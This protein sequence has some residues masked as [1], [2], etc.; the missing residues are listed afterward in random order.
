MVSLRDNT[1]MTDYWRA[2]GFD[3]A[4]LSDARDYADTPDA[5]VYTDSTTFGF[6]ARMAFTGAILKAADAAAKRAL[7]GRRA[8]LIVK[9]LKGAGVHATGAKS[10]N[11]NAR[12]TLDS[13]DVKGCLQR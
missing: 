9:Q 7:S 11:L 10:P 8:C 13:D 5:P 1:R 3:E 12:P 4:H 2:H 6:A